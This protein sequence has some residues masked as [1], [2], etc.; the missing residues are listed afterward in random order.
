MNCTMKKTILLFA[1]LLLNTFLFSQIKNP[2]KWAYTAKK[3]TAKTYEL[4]VTASIDEGWHIY[5]TQHKGT[6]GVA[7]SITIHNNPLD[8]KQGKMGTKANVVTLNDATTG[9]IEKFYTG[10]VDFVQVVELRASVKTNFT[11]VV[12]FM[13]CNNEQCLPP[14]T[15]SFSISIN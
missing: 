12:T 4:H 1:L 10:T 8:T 5:T 2:V 13:S 6:I 14:M 9:A 11:G 3:I 15:K 7:T